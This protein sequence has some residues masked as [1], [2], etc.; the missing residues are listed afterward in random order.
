MSNFLLDNQQTIAQ[1]AK[2]QYTNFPIARDM[3]AADLGSH[4][5]LYCHPTQAQYDAWDA[6]S[7]EER[8]RQ[9]VEYTDAYYKAERS[10]NR[11]LWQDILD[12]KN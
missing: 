8:T 12:A 1:I 10:G 5:E 7:K 6:L 3:F 2:K 11:W 4:K 9:L